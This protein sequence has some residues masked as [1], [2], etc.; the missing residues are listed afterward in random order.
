MADQAPGSL[1]P[2]QRLG[3]V[4]DTRPR[5]PPPWFAAITA[6]VGMERIRELRLSARNERGRSGERASPN[7]Y[8]LMVLAHGA[9]FVLPCLEVSLVGRR[10]RARW[11]WLALLAAAGGLRWWSIT[12]LGDAWNVRALVADD[13]P[14]ISRGPY[15]WIR[16]PNYVAVALEFLALPMVAGARSSAMVLSAANALLLWRRIRAE[17]RLLSKVPGYTAAMGG[18]ARFIPGIF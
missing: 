3:A 5:L 10:S 13:V 15:R 4:G 9:L 17:E 7:T 16:H 11:P 12:S 8:P 18:K 6:L 14:P 2:A 1:R